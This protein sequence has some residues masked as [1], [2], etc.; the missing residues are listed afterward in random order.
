MADKLVSSV[1][2]RRKD[3]ASLELCTMTERE[4]EHVLAG[5]VV[6]ALDGAPARCVYEV[7]CSAEWR[8]Q[9]VRVDLE[10]AGEL[11]TL[12][13]SAD[14]NG[15]WRRDDTELVHLRGLIDVDISVS[16]STNTLPIRRCRLERGQSVAVTAAWIRLPALTIEPLPQEYT[17]TGQQSY[18]Y[19]SRGGAFTADL[20]VDDFGLVVRYG[21]YWER[22]DLT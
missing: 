14:G 12:E 1:L 10:R 2:W 3:I 15:V 6:C 21:E 16:P 11:T 9:R 20:T 7:V 18:R 19:A 22:V 8:T 17:R 4:D 5:T 13:L